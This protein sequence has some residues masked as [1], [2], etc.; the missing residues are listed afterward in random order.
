MQHTCVAR[1][2][3]TMPL[4]PILLWS[5]EVGGMEDGYNTIAISE[6]LYRRTDLN[7]LS[8]C[9]SCYWHMFLNVK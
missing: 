7:N 9:L 5:K 6:T 4:V 3:A 1:H 8:G 2:W